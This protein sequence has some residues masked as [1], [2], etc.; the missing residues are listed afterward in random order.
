[1]CQAK[2]PRANGRD[3]KSFAEQVNE[4]LLLAREAKLCSKEVVSILQAWT[5]RRP[6]LSV[7][8]FSCLSPCENLLK[9]DVQAEPQRGGHPALEISKP[10]ELENLGQSD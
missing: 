5:Q 4:R 10:Q 8:W 9:R 1:M 2:H 3:P 7:F 6:G